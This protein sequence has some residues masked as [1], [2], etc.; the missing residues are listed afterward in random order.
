MIILQKLFSFNIK[1]KDLVNIYTLYIRSILEF[2]CQ[3]WHYSI[4]EEEKSDLEW[5]Q[6]VACRIILNEQYLDYEQA[7]GD[8]NLETLTDRRGKICLKFARTA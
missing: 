6:K 8:L 2:S 5:V 4:T 1:E 3:V 7:L